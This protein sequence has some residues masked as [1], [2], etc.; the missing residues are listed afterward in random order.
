[1]L[2]PV[3]ENIKD[4]IAQIMLNYEDLIKELSETRFC[5]QCFKGFIRRYEMNIHPPPTEVEEK[6]P[7]PYVSFTIIYR[8]SLDVPSSS[9]PLEMRRID[10]DEESYF[11][12]DDDDDDEGVAPGPHPAPTPTLPLIPPPLSRFQTPARRK[13]Q[14]SP[15]IPLRTGLAGITQR[16]AP[17]PTTPIHLPRTPPISAL[18]EY[19]DEDEQ[20][21]DPEESF[22]SSKPSSGAGTVSTPP[23][24]PLPPPP[25]PPPPPPPP[26]TTPLST[27]PTTTTATTTA[28]TGPG[29]GG[30]F[31]PLRAEKRRRAEEEEDEMGLE[32]LIGSK[33]KRS[34]KT[35][36]TGAGEEGPKR[37]RLRFGAAS[38]AA[39]SSTLP[40]AARPE[41]GAKDG[42][43]G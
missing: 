11:N 25:S 24:P 27:P 14:H 2:I 26:T 30:G 3:Q 31:V 13:R 1:M 20:T 40:T 36:A 15:S 35:G 37:I 12:G 33:T 18:V 38:L 16:V 17:A 5:G 34:A 21:S 29:V 41:S 43:T 22:V 4:V 23:P 19:G 6:P 8:A 7:P 28:G 10:I 32:R 9:Q 39:A 42:D